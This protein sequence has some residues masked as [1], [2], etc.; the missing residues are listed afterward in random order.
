ME[1]MLINIA[2][3]YFFFEK[4]ALCHSYHISPSNQANLTIF[5]EC[6]DNLF[7]KKI[8]TTWVAHMGNNP[9]SRRSV[10]CFAHMGN[11]I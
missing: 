1:G 3:Y 9:Y 4:Y 10:R 7:V 6:C 11:P 5:E 8:P 2:T